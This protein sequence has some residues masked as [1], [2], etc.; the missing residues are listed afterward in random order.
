MSYII[1]SL[2]SSIQ[3]FKEWWEDSKAVELNSSNF[4]DIV[5]KKKFV[6][7]KFY[8]KWCRFCKLMAEDYEHLV[9]QNKRDD[10]IIARL[11]GNANQNI[12]QKF[13]I[14]GFPCLML[15][16]PDN[17]DFYVIYNERERRLIDMQKFLDE[18]C[19]DLPSE[20]ESVQTQ[21]NFLDK[22]QEPIEIHNEP[23]SLIEPEIDE[24]SIDPV[25]TEE[26]KELLALR[27]KYLNLNT[28]YKNI[29]KELILFESILNSDSENILLLINQLNKEII[30]DYVKYYQLDEKIWN[31]DTFYKYT[32]VF[33]SIVVIYVIFAKLYKSLFIN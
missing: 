9:E 25:N 32:L 3:S 20:A 13:G 27:K 2:I 33:F 19:V 14:T 12:V 22:K 21:S 30:E 28:K 4:F 11:E 24:Q 10:I 6:F 5:G 15:F 31:Y 29:K 18:W 17:N 1:F 7:V 8:T 16:E 23:I 26:E